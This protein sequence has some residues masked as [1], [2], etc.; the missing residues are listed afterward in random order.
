MS[1]VYFLLTPKHQMVSEFE[2]TSL[3]KYDVHGAP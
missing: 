1:D 3:S 2:V